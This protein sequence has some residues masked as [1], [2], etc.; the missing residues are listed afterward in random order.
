MKQE[1]ARRWIAAWFSANPHS[2]A[3][4]VNAEFHA[5]FVAEFGQSLA[6]GQRFAY[7]PA[8]MKALAAMHKDGEL[9]RGRVTGLKAAGDEFPSWVWS[10]SPAGPAK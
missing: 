6:S 8:A 10:Y 4:A 3:S 7:H 5:A 2:D 9:R 1:D